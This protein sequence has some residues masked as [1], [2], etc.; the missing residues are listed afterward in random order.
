MILNYVLAAFNLLAAGYY[1][2]VLGEPRPVL[3][4][5]PWLANLVIVALTVYALLR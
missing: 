3:T 5:G 1:L 2:S 4:F